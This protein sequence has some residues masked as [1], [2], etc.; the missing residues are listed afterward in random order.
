LPAHVLRAVAAGPLAPPLLPPVSAAPSLLDPGYW[1]I[2][3]GYTIAPDGAARVFVLT[4]MPGV[5]PAMWAWWFA[6]HGSDS[7]RYR[8]WHPGAHVAARWQDGQ[9][10][11]GAY[12]GRVCLVDE[13]IGARLARIAI[14]FVPPARLGISPPARLD[15]VRPATGLAPPPQGDDAAVFICAQGG[16]PGGGVRLGW[17]VHHIRAVPGGAEMRSR[18]W[19]GGENIASPFGR[20]GRAVAG[21]AA[22]IGRE[23]A[24]DLLVHCAQEMNHLA[25]FLPEL[26]AAFGPPA[27]VQA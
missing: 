1:P 3:T 24:A 14:G 27:A 10:E 7:A 12:V 26:Y 25:A 2:E 22:R 9:G 23:N 4:E 8:L 15:I 20:L 16:A 19:L 13:Y 17:L 11:T 21:R 5:T 6:W 18:F